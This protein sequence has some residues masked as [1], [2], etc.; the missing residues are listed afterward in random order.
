[1]ADIDKA[2]GLARAVVQQTEVSDHNR[3]GITEDLARAVLAM[4]AAV[5]AARAQAAADEARFTTGDDDGDSPD[6]WLDACD[7]TEHA[8]RARDAGDVRCDGDHGEPAC[9][10]ATCWQLDSEEVNH[11]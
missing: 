8:I 7:A 3:G 5:K 6:V 9:S 2:V 11:G 4:A 1:M 10:D